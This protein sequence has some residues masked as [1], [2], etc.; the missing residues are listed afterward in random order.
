MRP[1]LS[2]TVGVCSPR[3][4]RQREMTSP[5]TILSPTTSTTTTAST[6]TMISR[7][8]LRCLPRQ[9]I[10]TAR[11]YSSKPPGPGLGGSFGNA[12]PELGVGEISNA[13]FRISPLR[14]HGEDLATMRARLLCMSL[15]SLSLSHSLSLFSCLTRTNTRTHAHRPI[16]EARDPGDGSAAVDVCRRTVADDGA[17]AAGAV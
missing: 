1:G 2:D 11:F 16:P 5:T 9:L 14:R 15:I 3:N 17:G 13:T 8:L 10:P 12:S 7:S 6:E 4:N